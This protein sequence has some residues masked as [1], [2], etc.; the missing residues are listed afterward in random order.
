MQN[1]ATVTPGKIS[2]ILSAATRDLYATGGEGTLEPTGRT[3]TADSGDQYAE[4]RFPWGEIY[5]VTDDD[6]DVST[7]LETLA[8]EELDENA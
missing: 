7:D 3:H 4:I 6:A 8:L 5:W 2:E 1:T